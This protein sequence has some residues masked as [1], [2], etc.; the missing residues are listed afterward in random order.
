LSIEKEAQYLWV[1]VH[2]D[3]IYRYDKKRKSWRSYQPRDPFAC[4]LFNYEGRIFA[5]EPDRIY[6]PGS[7]LRHIDLERNGFNEI[8]RPFMSMGDEL[9]GILR[10]RYNDGDKGLCCYNPRND[11]WKSYTPGSGI[12]LTDLSPRDGHVPFFSSWAREGKVIWASAHPQGVFA[13]DR[14]HDRWKR[15]FDI[16]YRLPPDYQIEQIAA[17]RRRVYF[18]PC[19]VSS[20]IM[21]RFMEPMNFIVTHNRRT[22]AIEKVP[23]PEPLAL[24]L[25]VCEKDDVWLGA[26]D[27]SIW[28]FNDYAST[29]KK[30]KHGTGNKSNWSKSAKIIKLTDSF[31]FIGTYDGLYMRRR[32]EAFSLHQDALTASLKKI[33]Q[34]RNPVVVKF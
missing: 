5:V 1:L 11:R 24:N 14:T 7:E 18:I 28:R 12:G 4:S 3:G 29:W 6:R 21:G 8:R 31:I 17:T 27:G 15:I 26:L 13:F 30:E 10:D 2:K 25:A 20:G 9:W 34:P 33:E 16:D 32:H 19:F 22:K 23:L